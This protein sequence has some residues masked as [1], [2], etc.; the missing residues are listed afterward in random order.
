MAVP[1]ESIKLDKSVQNSEKPPKQH[2]YFMHRDLTLFIRRKRL[3]LLYYSGNLNRNALELLR[4]QLNE[5]NL[6]SGIVKKVT[7]AA[8]YKDLQRMARWEPFIWAMLSSQVNAEKDAE[9]YLK[10]LELARERAVALMLA[11]GSDKVKVDAIGKLVNIVRNQIKLRQSLGQLPNV[12]RPVINIGS[13]TQ[14]Q[15]LNIIT[16]EELLKEYDTLVMANRR[17]QLQGNDTAKSV[18]SMETADNSG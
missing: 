5:S 13:L 11:A 2:S 1:A 9:E 6:K 15:Q 12:D 18:D 14:N 16:N 8:L 10:F 17:R 4:G 7:M 3:L